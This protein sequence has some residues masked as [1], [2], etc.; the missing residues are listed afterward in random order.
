MSI[1]VGGARAREYPVT[2][3]G[4]ALNGLYNNV[5]LGQ[6]TISNTSSKRVNENIKHFVHLHNKIYIHAIFHFSF[7]FSFH[8]IVLLDL[9]TI[10]NTRSKRVNGNITKLCTFPE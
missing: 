10:S 9:I 3:I 2:L 1:H 5:L 7:S 8:Y 4:K 6:K